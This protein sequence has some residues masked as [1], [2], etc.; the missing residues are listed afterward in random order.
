[1]DRPLD[2][3]ATFET[4]TQSGP[5]TAPARFAIRQVLDQEYQKYIIR[6]RADAR[7][8]RYGTG[9]RILDHDVDSGNM[10]KENVPFESEWKKPKVIAAKRDFFG[11]IIN[12]ARPRSKDECGLDEQSRKKAKYVPGEEEVNKVWVS[13]HEGFSNAVRKPITLDELMRGL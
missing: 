8:A 6:Q 10:D 11:R 12:E 3:L 2:T 5:A 7:Q 9:N 4:A 13:F 1:M